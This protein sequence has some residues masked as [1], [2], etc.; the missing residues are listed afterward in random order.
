MGCRRPLHN[1]ILAED[2]V[3]HVLK[4]LQDFGPRAADIVNAEI[5]LRPLEEHPTST[6]EDYRDGAYRTLEERELLHQRILKELISETRL[7][8]DD[9][10]ALGCGGAKP[11]GTTALAQ[12]Y[13]V[14]GAPAS[15]K[16]GV[17]SRLADE[18]GAY[19]L[20]SDYAKRKFPEYRQYPG[21]ASLVHHESDSI[22]FGPTDSLF[23][24]CIYSRYNVVI[25]LV[26]RTYSS[27]EKVCHRLKEC[28]Y[29]IHIINVPLD[30]YECVSRAYRRFLDT[31]RYVPL[32]YI[33]DEVGNEPERI[34][35]LLKRAYAGDNNFKSFSQLSTKVTWGKP[36]VVVEATEE[37]PV[38]LWNR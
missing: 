17:A 33:F 36:P 1:K 15:G 24:Y 28:G 2:F 29:Y 20:D 14:S 38:C 4:I 26:G 9:D 11:S 7:P 8:N 34:Y 6:H 5:N 27:V 30:R 16:S 22:V 37:S 19:I 31:G 12:A 32:S 3:K 35:F 10:I 21:G 23:E 13:I 25:P 18:N